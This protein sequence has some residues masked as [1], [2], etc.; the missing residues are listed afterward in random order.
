M[1]AEMAA[2]KIVGAVEVMGEGFEVKHFPGFICLRVP[3]EDRH[4]WSPRLNLSLHDE[5]GTTRV[6]GTYGP[7]ANVWSLFLYGYLLAGSMALF[8]GCLG[9]AQWSLGTRAWGLW[10][11]GGAV[12]VVL[13][14]YIGAQM[15]Q[16]IGAQQQFRLHQAYE[17]AVGSRVEL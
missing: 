2:A 11:C 4:F 10:I 12:V 14:L 7:N 1:S 17:A 3:M 6:E 13:G 16:K 9:F 5:A 15:G 8:S